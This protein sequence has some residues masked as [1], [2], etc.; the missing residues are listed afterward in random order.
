MLDAKVQIP[1]WRLHDLRRGQVA[2][3]A[4]QDGA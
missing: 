2:T 4:G 1:E 3:E